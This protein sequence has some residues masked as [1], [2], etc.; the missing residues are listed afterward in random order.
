[1]LRAAGIYICCN[2][3]GA[4][5]TSR[6]RYFFERYFLAGFDREVSGQR[7]AKKMT[8]AFSCVYKRVAPGA[9]KEREGTFASMECRV[10]RGV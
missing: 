1:M 10:P 4:S 3:S 6:P 2:E 5:D 8:Y 9:A 7:V